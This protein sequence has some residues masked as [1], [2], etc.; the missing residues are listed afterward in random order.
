MTARN[1]PS[2]SLKGVRR[3]YRA[4]CDRCG[5]K[6]YNWQLRD[7]W[8][9]LMVCH[10]PST[11]DCWEPRHPQ[12]FLRPVKENN[13]LPWTRPEPDDVFIVGCS[14]SS[15]SGYADHGAAGCMKAGWEPGGP[16]MSYEDFATIYG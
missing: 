2:R 7:E 1:K 8:T 10:G 12:D 11:N 9:G 16:N 6:Y 14:I 13:K 5:S 3:Q 15:S 4:L